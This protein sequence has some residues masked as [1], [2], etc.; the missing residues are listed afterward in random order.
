MVALRHSMS[1]NTHSSSAPSSL[2]MGR[3]GELIGGL[4]LDPDIPLCTGEQTDNIVTV[5]IHRH[6]L[7]FMVI[8]KSFTGYMFVSLTPP[9]E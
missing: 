5:F 9:H 8:V 7:V 4:V 3:E 2:G 1:R 6:S